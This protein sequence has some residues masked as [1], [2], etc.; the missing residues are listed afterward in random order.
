MLFGSLYKKTCRYFKH[1]V[2]FFKKKQRFFQIKYQIF[3]ILVVVPVRCSESAKPI[4]TTCAKL[5]GESLH[6]WRVDGN[7]YQFDRPVSRSR[8]LE[9]IPLDQ[10]GGEYK[11]KESV[12]NIS[13]RQKTASANS[14]LKEASKTCPIYL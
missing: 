10:L 7:L 4:P 14:K 2:L 8:K 5:L 1:D 3:I 6:R 12:I 9:D 11:N 13:I